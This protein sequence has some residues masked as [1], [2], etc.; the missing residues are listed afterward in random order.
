MTRTFLPSRVAMIAPSAA[1]WFRVAATRVVGAGW[2]RGQGVTAQPR[3][4]AAGRSRRAQPPGSAAD[5][6]GGALGL[7]GDAV[8]PVD[9]EEPGGD[10]VLE[11]TDH[12]RG[13]S[14]GD[15]G[16][17][18]GRGVLERDAVRR[19]DAEQGGGAEVPVRVGLAVLD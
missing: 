19:L 12:D 14:G 1:R 10:V 7:H 16:R 17:E 5:A 4:A 13:R 18:P 15:G 3:G 8:V 9:P 11:S 2:V 6:E